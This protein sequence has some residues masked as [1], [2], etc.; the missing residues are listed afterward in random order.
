MFFTLLITVGVVVVVVAVRLW[1]GD[2]PFPLVFGDVATRDIACSCI[3]V[4]IH[5]VSL[6]RPCEGQH[7]RLR[8]LLSAADVFSALT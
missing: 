2:D 7:P 8:H 3:F 6:P 1:R 4:M 5:E